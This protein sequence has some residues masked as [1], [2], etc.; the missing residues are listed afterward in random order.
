MGI[1]SRDGEVLVFRAMSITTGSISAATPMLFINADKMPV[2]RPML[3]VGHLEIGQTSLMRAEALEA[4]GVRLVKFNSRKFLDA[5][6]L[7]ERTVGRIIARSPMVDTMNKAL[8]EA[9]DMHNPSVVWCDKQEQLS[10]ETINTIKKI[11]ALIEIYNHDTYYAQ[12]W[13]RTTLSDELLASA[14]IAVTTKSWEVDQYRR[15]CETVYMPHGYCERAHRQ[16]VVPQQSRVDLVLVST[17]PRWPAAS[18][19]L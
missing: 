19:Q 17:T 4:L 1:N 6:S 2:E 14:D 9:V 10:R 3:Y 11:G 8:R 7:V 12:P 15:I 16:V 5:R 13:M 18:G